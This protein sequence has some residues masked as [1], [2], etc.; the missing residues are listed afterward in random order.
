M[1]ITSL[2]F[3]LSCLMA[4]VSCSDQTQNAANSEGDTDADIPAWLIAKLD[5]IVI[6]KIEIDGATIE[7]AVEFAR[8]SSIQYD[9]ER[10]TTLR[11]VSFIVPSPRVA[12]DGEPDEYRGIG[13]DDPAQMKTMTYSAKNVRLLDFVR[14]IARQGEMD[15]YLT[16]VG[17]IFVPEGSAPF[18]NAKVEQGGDW[19]I[20]RRDSDD[21]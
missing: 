17:I 7:E 5:R 4:I 18:P 8:M 16:S 19:K 20:L 12:E 9:P 3:I 6:P 21:R 11:G 15:A 13:I 10:D 1:K 14:E 2:P